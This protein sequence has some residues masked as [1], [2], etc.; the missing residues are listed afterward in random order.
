MAQP[1]NADGATMRFRVF[2]QY[3]ENETPDETSQWVNRY[4]LRLWNY[5]YFRCDLDHNP[6]TNRLVDVYLCK[7]GDAGSEQGFPLDYQELDNQD[8][9]TR[10]NVIYIYQIAHEYGHSILP[11]VTGFEAPES[12]ANGDVGERIF[13]SWFRDDLKAGKIPEEDTFFTSQAQLDNYYEK[14]VKPMVVQIGTKGPDFSLFK[15]IPDKKLSEKAYM[16]YVGITTYLSRICPPMMFARFVNLTTRVAADTEKAI[17]SAAEERET[18]EL[19]V[20]DELKGK[21]MYIPLVKGK[22]SGAK[23]L[24]KSGNWA[25]IQPEANKKVVITNPPLPPQAQ[26][27]K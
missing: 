15:E 1:L 21:A 14:T 12:Y 17:V 18:W 23:I 27:L 6:L 22:V 2:S 4:M 25:M 11:I 7:E 26:N 8:R 10:K 5:G 20:P 24:K 19:T 13:L 3:R 16:E 9:P